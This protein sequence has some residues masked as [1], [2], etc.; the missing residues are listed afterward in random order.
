MVGLDHI[1]IVP[2]QVSAKTTW[3]FVRLEGRDGTIGLGEATAF[4]HEPIVQQQIAAL[5][6]SLATMNAAAARTRVAEAMAEAKGDGERA[7]LSALDQALFD[8][9]ARRKG[10]SGDALLGAATEGSVRVYANI[11]RGTVDRSPEGHA[12]RAEAAVR[13][14]YDAIKLAPFDDVRAGAPRAA[15]KHGI[16]RV[17]A[18]RD[19]V[20][21]RVAVAVDCHARF[22]EG[23]A[24]EMIALLTEAHPIWIEEPLAETADNASALRRLRSHA[25]DRGIMIAGAETVTGLREAELRIAAGGMDVMLPDIRFCGG[26]EVALKIAERVDA[27]GLCFS[28][29]NPVGPVLDAVSLSVAAAAPAMIMLERTFREDPIQARLTIPAMKDPGA[30]GFGDRTAPGWGLDL[31]PDAM[32]R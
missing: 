11:N 16:D 6:G 19:R 3:C 18:V 10:V 27:A 26:V 1:A 21:P 7:A 14:G 2:V 23:T 20:G 22:E 32:D 5:A 24:R 15:V 29:H 12:K 31:S 4:G 13:A 25:N 8:M 9:N 17:F 30:P 28:L